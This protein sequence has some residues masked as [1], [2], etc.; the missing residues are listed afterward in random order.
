V[1]STTLTV[2]RVIL[3]TGDLSGSSLLFSGSVPLISY[4]PVL[5]PLGLKDIELDL[6]NH[7]SDKKAVEA[8]QFLRG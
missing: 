2:R 6:G 5:W 1:L 7:T 4:R 3:G 8:F